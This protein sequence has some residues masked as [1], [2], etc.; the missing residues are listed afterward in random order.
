MTSDD[1][2]NRPAHRNKALTALYLV[3]GISFLGAISW[4]FHRNRLVT[5]VFQYC[6]AACVITRLLLIVGRVWQ[7]SRA[8]K[9]LADTS[10]KVYSFPRRFGLGT[11]LVLTLVFGALSAYFR[12]LEW[13]GEVVLAALCFVGLVSA[14]QFAF[15]R[16]PRHVSVLV[17]SL[18][19]AA[20]PI[21]WRLLDTRSFVR[22]QPFDVAFFSATFAIMGALVGY[23]TGT[24]VG[25]IFLLMDSAAVFLKKTPNRQTDQA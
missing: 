23:C 6:F 24:L 8:T 4:I 12:S 18:V 15:D 16:A 19:F 14:M 20:W 13:R 7:L 2:A 9:D 11:L 17:G 21:A 22:Y 25:G 10:R 1:S 5:H 3:A